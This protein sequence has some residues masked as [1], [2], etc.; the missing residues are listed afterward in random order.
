MGISRRSGNKTE[1]CTCRRNSMNSVNKRAQCG[2]S[3]IE[4][5][6][7]VAIMSVLLGLLAPQYVRY[8]T[9]KKMTTCQHN[10]E[11]IL[12]IYERAVYDGSTPI[13]LDN[14]SI[15]KVVDNGGIGYAPTKNEVAQYLHCPLDESGRSWHAYISSDGTP[16]I[17]CEKCAA[18]GD[19]DSRYQGYGV[20]SIDMLGWSPSP[21]SIAVDKEREE[22]VYPTP[23]AK[24]EEEYIVSFNLLGRGSPKPDDQI[25]KYGEKATRPADPT[26]ATYK[27]DGWYTETNFTYKYTFTEAV[28]ADVV[29]YAKWEGIGSS[30]VWPYADDMTW[31]D[32]ELIAKEHSGEYAEFKYDYGSFENAEIKLYVPTGIFTSRAGAQYVLIDTNSTGVSPQLQYQ[33]MLNPERYSAKYPQYLIQL[34][35]NK[36]TYDLSKATNGKIYPG[37]VQN[38]DLI[39]FVQ[40]STVYLYVYFHTD[41]DDTLSTNGI[42]VSEITAYTN[43]IGNM[44]RVNK[45]PT[46]KT[47]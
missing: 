47:S 23:T 25:V 16:C 43:K 11:A 40:D 33:Y 24:V 38:G 42:N 30:S 10:R 1:G 13:L 3:L 31:W 29:L 28:T 19:A 37:A 8:V 6:I 9:A 41:I 2:F 45:T 5:I 27:F 22:P 14:D 18:K 39:E 36:W 26:A 12:R 46:T 35:G 15:K 20:V 4:L 17:E 32:P 44:Y 21:T 7:V 34:T